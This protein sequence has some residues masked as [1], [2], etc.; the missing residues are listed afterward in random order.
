MRRLA[1][2]LTASVIAAA[3]SS[4]GASTTGSDST[5]SA[6]DDTA[7][8]ATESADGN[9]SAEDT[10]EEDTSGASPETTTTTSNPTTTTAVPTEADVSE[11]GW[12]SCEGIEGLECSTLAV[13]LDH[14][15]PEGQAIDIA[16]ARQPAGDPANRIGSLVFN[17]G[18]PGGSGI[19]FLEFA[20]FAIP[21]DVADR[22]DLV[23]FDPRGVGASAAV[24]CDLV[25]DDGVEL[26]A[27][28]DRAAWDALLA[29]S[30]TDLGTCTAEPGALGQYVGT[31]NAARDLD[32]IRAALGDEQLSYVGFSYGTRLGATYAEL[33]PDRVRALVLDGAVKPTTDLAQL[34]ADQGAGFD[35]AF[36]NFA[37][38]CDADPDCLLRE[39]GPTLDVAAAVRAE[40]ARAGSFTTDDPERVL[41]PGELDLGIISALYSKD[42][43]P[44]L[45]QAIYL[46]DTVADGSLFQVL[47]DNY[48]GRRPDGSYANQTEANAFINCADDAAR[49]D[50]DSTWQ[51]ADAVAAGSRYFDDA[52]RASTGC[53]GIDDAIDPLVLGPAAGAAPILVIGT[54]G[55]PATPYEWSVEM[56]D[57]L[58]SGVLYSVEAEGHTAYTS[59]DC[60]SDVVGAY[61]IDLEVPDEGGSCADDADTDFFVP[62]GESD[63]ELIVAFFDCLIEQGVDLEPVTVADVLADP[64]GEQLFGDLDFNDPAVA[65]A[66]VECRSL[67]PA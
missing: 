50:V 21:P 38:A 62:A 15:D 40:I 11:L 51:E 7:E 19:E 59:I 32:R 33:F 9:G 31:N 22:F 1:V 30:L 12:S 37:A 60:V 28:G 27:D 35:N 66:I 36:E 20:V 61:L 52:L 46:A 34:G 58:E 26:V 14:A 3:C 39:L 13:P 25:L 8:E 53:L 49:P 24:E 47:A 6:S 65:N 23:S 10:A 55:D 56:A 17:P 48:L 2:L 42:A 57:S 18:G 16:L 4:G 67:L 29:S 43:W 5:P 41:T 64:A 44:F 63:V 45:A 54:T